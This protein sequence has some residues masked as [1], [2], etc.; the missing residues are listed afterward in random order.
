M[1]QQNIYEDA[2][3]TKYTLTYTLWKSAKWLS[4]TKWNKLSLLRG[5][6]RSKGF[7]FQAPVWTTCRKCPGSRG[8]W[9]KTYIAYIDELVTQPGEN[10]TFTHMMSIWI[11]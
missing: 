1:K 9:Q 7:P 4:G 11:T 2:Y 5:G 8:R 6:L 10:P 3:L